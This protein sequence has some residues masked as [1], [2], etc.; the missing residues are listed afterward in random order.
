MERL[1]VKKIKRLLDKGYSANKIVKTIGK[2]KQDVLREIRQIQNKPINPVK[3]TNPKGKIG[4]IELDKPSQ[5][6]TEKL[7]K[8]GYPISF[9]E[10]LVNAKHKETSQRKI[11]AYI[12]QYKTENK[13]AYESHKAN[14][15][16]YQATG[17]FK[18]R[19]DAKWFR[20]LEYHYHEPNYQFKVGSPKIEFDE[21]D[22]ED[23][24]EVLPN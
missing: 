19:Q 8:E 12:K 16:F 4:S 7:Y 5:A 11:R 22:G 3:I 2:R 13:E 23:I 1:P 14:M 24:N 6:F 18:Q 10:K 15:R 17:K 20:E 9:I 21:E